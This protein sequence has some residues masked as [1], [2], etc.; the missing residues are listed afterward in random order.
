MLNIQISAF[1]HRLF[2][3]LIIG[4]RHVL[5]YLRRAPG[6]ERNGAPEVTL[7]PSCRQDYQTAIQLFT[8]PNLL[9][10]VDPVR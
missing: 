1:S 5:A 6:V 9:Q 2:C 7:P 3:G 4:Q 8:H 10:D